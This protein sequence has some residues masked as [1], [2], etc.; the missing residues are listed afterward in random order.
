VFPASLEKLG[1]AIET[2]AFDK[3]TASRARLAAAVVR[4]GQSKVYYT[5]KFGYFL[6]FLD[7]VPQVVNARTGAKV[8]P[9]ELK[10]LGFSSEESALGVVAALSSSTFFWFWN[11]LSD[12][13]N[14]NR[15]DLLAFPFDPNHVSPEFG[16]KIF[17]LGKVY[18]QKLRSTSKSMIKSG[19]TIETFD[20]AHC[21]QIIDEIDVLLA[22]YF[23]LDDEELDFIINY[24]IKYRMGG[25]GINAEE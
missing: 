20:Y 16:C 21:K 12:C 9:S 23:G 24:D 3:L 1:S 11:V 10:D 6:A 22:R 18:L 8:P 14:L 5:R 2:K 7:F 15:R 17:E 19:L 4:T 13:R 25:G